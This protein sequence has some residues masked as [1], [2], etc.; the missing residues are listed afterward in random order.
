VRGG[1][2]A[3]ARARIF[4]DSLDR[5]C[6]HRVARPIFMGPH[7]NMRPAYIDISLLALVNPPRARSMGARCVLAPFLA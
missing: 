5:V 3:R 4:Y 2:A 6:H 7:K 1:D